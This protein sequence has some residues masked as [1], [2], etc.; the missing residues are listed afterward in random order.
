MVSRFACA[1]QGGVDID[2]FLMFSWPHRTRDAAF[3]H[4]ACRYGGHG[5]A[6]AAPSGAAAPLLRQGYA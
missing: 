2:Q 3:G 1:C 5:G 6:A 4:G